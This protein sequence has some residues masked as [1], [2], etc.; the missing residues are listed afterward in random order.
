MYSGF[1]GA[2]VTC[3]A[4][5]SD[6]RQWLLLVTVALMMG[7]WLGILTGL[8]LTLSACTANPAAVSTTIAV[9]DPPETADSTTT[10][11]VPSTTQA[12]T[13][14]APPMPE[15]ANEIPQ[16][17]IELATA[18]TEAERELRQ[19]TD[20]VTRI[21]W[22]E[23][24]QWLY[25]LVQSKSETEAEEIL[26]LA[27]GGPHG[28]AIALNI[29]ARQALTALVNNYEISS[30]LP[31]WSIEAPRPPDELLQLYMSAEAQTGI[32]WEY[33]AAIN[34]VETRMGRINGVSTAGA[35]GPMQFLPT[36]WA[37]CCEGDPTVPADA[38]L[39]AGQYLVDRGGPGDMDRA[40]LGYNN[41]KNYV[42]AVKAYAEVLR[43]DPDAYYGYHAW[44]VYFQST[45]GL[46]RL[47]VGY[48]ETE[49]IDA[50]TWLAENPDSLVQ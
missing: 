45:A 44:Q 12:P 28:D 20:S 25:Q 13:T 19:A 49:S 8:A 17:M 43:L 9:L 24:Q 35:V 30:T 7:R 1:G 40:I 21:F 22:G 15:V 37:E 32:D 11:T 4:R 6:L 3:D 48:Y 16:G 29:E 2:S 14:T 47:G 5:L 46:A 39:G 26:L 33:L 50:A 38:I 10:L 36:T 23:R 31:A 18:L 27:S 34:L 42:T 41:S